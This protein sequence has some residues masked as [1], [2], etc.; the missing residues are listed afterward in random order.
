MTSERHTLST[1][2]RKSLQMQEQ[3]KS[4]ARNARL[5]TDRRLIPLTRHL[6]KSVRSISS[7]TKR[8]TSTLNSAKLTSLALPQSS[9]DLS[10]NGR[11][12]AKL[13]GWLTQSRTKKMKSMLQVWPALRTPRLH[14]NLCS[15]QTEDSRCWMNS[16]LWSIWSA[17]TR[18]AM[19][20]WM[21]EKTVPSESSQI[22]NLQRWPGNSSIKSAVT[23]WS[24]TTP[25]SLEMS[26]LE[27]MGVSFL[28][29]QRTWRANSGGSFSI[30]QK[31]IPRFSQ[32]FCSSKVKSS[33]L[34]MTLIC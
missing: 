29:L 28:S 33:G 18:T 30:Q 15:K 17:S 27:F 1:H 19:E 31:K 32:D 3:W 25:L 16:T 20:G 6:S 7:L 5:L 9:S 21:N 14:P 12:P 24:P 26:R 22:C 4:S 34:R 10:K 8:P 2:C 11:M 13:L 23:K